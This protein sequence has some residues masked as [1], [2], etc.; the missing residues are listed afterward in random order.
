M[1]NY[2]K[3]CIIIMHIWCSLVCSS[4]SP[5]LLLSFRTLKSKR[6]I[7]DR[8]SE[9]G[10]HTNYHLHTCWKLGVTTFFFVFLFFCF[11][12]EC[13]LSCINAMLWKLYFLEY[14]LRRGGSP[15]G[16]LTNLTLW[17]DTPNAERL[18]CLSEY[19]SGGVLKRCYDTLTTCL[20]NLSRQQVCFLLC[21]LPP[22]LEIT[23]SE[24]VSCFIRLP[25]EAQPPFI[26]RERQNDSVISCLITQGK[27]VV[28]AFVFLSSA[29][30]FVPLH[31][32]AV[33]SKNDRSFT[34]R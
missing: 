6:G 30:F 34:Y 31:S 33:C 15:N 26:L 4:N 25:Q 12:H 32:T 14:F 18:R 20:P 16:D 3:S 1:H 13:A 24:V 17:P 28:W 2:H 23:L 8:W 27:L 29:F 19:Y 10:F 22:K 11:F 5:V 7:R 21:Y 9:G